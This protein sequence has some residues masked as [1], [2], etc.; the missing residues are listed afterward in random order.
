MAEKWMVTEKPWEQG[1]VVLVEHY[2]TTAHFTC[3]VK[4]K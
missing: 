2:K 1:S 3:F 4:K